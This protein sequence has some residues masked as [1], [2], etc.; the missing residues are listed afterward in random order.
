MKKLIVFLILMLLI[1]PISK[2]TFFYFDYSN[3][4]NATFVSKY[5]SR[6]MDSQTLDYYEKIKEDYN[7][8]IIKDSSVATNSQEWNEAYKNSN[9][10]FVT[11]LND[12]SLNES[13]DDFCK[14]LAE[15]L[16]ES[17]GLVFTGNSLIFE[18][19][20]TGNM[21][22]CLY[23]QY[24]NFAEGYN[25]SKLIKNNFKISE[26][27]EITE[28]YLKKTY[29]MD[30]E[31][32]IYP[33]V[34][35]KNGL[36]LATVNGDPD[37]SG[38]LSSED[39][40]LIVLWQ[41]ITYNIL[42][43]GITTSKLTGCSECVGW[44]LFKQSLDWVSDKQNMGFDFEMNKN[45][46]FV[47]ERININVTSHVEIDYVEG[48]IIYPNS[49]TYSLIFTG[50][51]KEWE[52]I[53]LLQNEDPTG[54]YIISVIANELEVRK[55]ITVNVM[56]IDV[57]VDNSSEN[58]K[59]DV[60]VKDKDGKDL[61]SEINITVE[62]ESG[63]KN[64]YH[65]IDNSS[66]NLEYTVTESGDHVVYV[67]VKDNLG[68]MQN[69]QKEFYFKLRPNITFTPKNITETVND[70]INLTKTIYLK[71]GGD[72]TL[73][74]VSIQKGG[75]I[76][77]WI[78]VNETEFDITKGYS[79]PIEIEI[80]ISEDGEGEYKGF[81]NFS[82]DQGFQIFYITIN[83]DYLGKLEVE[84][85]TDEIWLTIDE[86]TEV[87]FNLKNSGKGSLE[88][89]SVTPSKDIEDWVYVGRKPKT[90]IPNGEDKIIILVS[91]ENVVI[92]ET[93][94]TIIGSF[95]ISTDVGVYYPSPTLTL[96][97]VSDI[98]RDV[99]LF[100]PDLIEVE[101]N[102][103]KLKEK[104]DVSSYQEE[105]DRIRI[106][107]VNTQEVY[108]NGQLETAYQMYTG[109]ETDVNNLKNTVQQKENELIEGKKK[110]IRIGI[111]LAVI[112][113]VSI[114]G[115]LIYKKVKESGHYSWLYKKWKK[116]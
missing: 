7:I 30:E 18:G 36:T 33:I 20:E 11:N 24:F 87:E 31:K 104:T 40:P 23:T 35:P 12:Y 88:I 97:I 70:V 49:E 100:Y 67:N 9:L 71:N 89:K 99:E 108:N 83:L 39:Y 62:K 13:R 75:E 4:K 3:K 32:N 57:T 15:S 72:E 45:D 14:N 85:P 60:E 74:N 46:Y 1:I 91:A 66:V 114:V 84:S 19:N 113:V 98:S 10:I 86:A 73:T 29:N 96:K 41:G 38:P 22:S 78:G 82:S 90:L 95:N 27:H 16:D 43:F 65:Y 80:N 68:R 63:L 28:G 102:L 61:D 103:E 92:P 52:S 64:Y 26:S 42:S 59:I 107:I 51:E 105:V 44:N 106:K 8:Y 54:K 47:G 17:V 5:D 58:V 93:L 76:S 21:S 101:K 116:S 112:V 77:E 50:S 111:T 110:L 79:I 94:K 6:S 25:N 53:Y 115:Y 34:S 81:L 48:E 56:D 69:I 55:N 2:A 109:I 37:G